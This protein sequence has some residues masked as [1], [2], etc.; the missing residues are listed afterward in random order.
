MNKKDKKLLTLLDI[1]P[2][3]LEDE[4]TTTTVNRGLKYF[5]DG[6]VKDITGLSPPTEQDE[7]LSIEGVVAGRDARLYKTIVN[8]ELDIFGV[9]I[10]SRCSCPVEHNCKHGIALLFAFLNASSQQQNTSSAANDNDLTKSDIEVEQ[11]LQAIEQIEEEQESNINIAPPSPE[12][13][14]F[15]L[16]YILED[17]QP[18]YIGENNEGL[19][20]RYVKARA[21]KKGGYGQIYNINYYDIHEAYY[22]PNCFYNALDETIVT[23]LNALPSTGYGIEERFFLSSQIGEISLENMLKTGRCFW[24]T[25]RSAPLHLGEVRPVTLSWEDK[26]EV[27]APTI[28]IDPPVD[29]LF[30]LERFYYLDTQQ[31]KIGRAEHE[32]L[33]KNKIIFFKA[34]PTIPKNNAEAMSKKILNALPSVDFPLP[35]ELDIQQIEITDIRPNFHLKLHAVQRPQNPLTPNVSAGTMHIASLSFQYGEVNYKPK[36]QSDLDKAV[37]VFLEDGNRYTL[38]RALA[39]EQGAIHTLEAIGFTPLTKPFDISDMALLGDE[40]VAQ[41]I[42]KW[43]IFQTEKIPELRAAGWR[44]DIDDSFELEL[45]II[46]DWFADLDESEAGDWFEMNLGFELNGVRVNLL[47]L[48]VQLLADNPDKDSLHQSLRDKTHQIFQLPSG[49]WIKIPTQR[50]LQIL[51]TIIELYDTD[52]LTTD[53][54]LNIDKYAGLHFNELLNDPSLRWKGADELKKLNKKLRNFEGIESVDLPKGLSAELRN[55]QK[56]GL[57]WLQ[58]L[59][60][61]QFHGI[62]ADDMGLGKTVQTLANLLLEK[63]NGR[64]DLPSVVIAP[65]S[66]MSN[67]KN[68]AKKFTPDLSVLILQGPNRKDHFDKIKEYDLILTTYPLM[69]RDKELY[70]DNE[71][72]YL[73]LDEAQAIKNVKAKTTQIIYKI[74]ARHRL[75]VTGTPMENHLGEIWSM[76]HFLMPGYLGTHERFNRLFRNPIEKNA[77]ETRGQVLRQRIEPFLLRRSKEV[78][79]TELPEK[80]EMIRMVT[81]SGKQRDLYETVR[82]AMDKKVRDEI[83][84]KGLARS[85]IMILDALLKLRQVCCDPKLVKLEKARKV[86]ESA[87]L[88]LLMTMVPEM[89]EEGRKILIFSQ[90]TAML[91]IIEAKLKKAKIKYTKLTGQTRKRAEAIDAFQEGDA[92]VFLISLKA[93]GVGLNLTAADTVIHY[94]PWWNPAAEKQATDRAYR[95]GQDKPVFVYK[96]LTEGTVEEKILL[97][98]EKKQALA[99]ALYAKKDNT[100]TSFDQ[101]DL[102]DLLKPLE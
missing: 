72:H 38:H 62:L 76:Y 5:N 36:T 102:M 65:T 74:K 84:K 61:Y 70:Q 89:L 19:A 11:W 81:L 6:H 20:V 56:E 39:D 42:E 59:R 78:V 73:I 24:Q 101:N 15:H 67:W 1:N 96:L 94:D 44:I 49:Q 88:E 27:Y 71:F 85:H 82:L 87:K 58:F 75:C 16:I 13:E 52:A 92:K 18:R 60:N 4:F 35:V 64:A 40:S 54:T 25:Q 31:H 45:E 2:K 34:A 98:Q 47:P 26:G 37:A 7:V 100:Q 79:A 68:E 8:I 21:L 55:Y 99:D 97:M 86:K 91:G 80:T 57:N 46:D 77:D 12:V 10:D 29:N 23:A 43:D 3:Y 14:N 48:L 50:V 28:N 63:E 32:S 93:G 41:S 33:D 53:G 9:D 90:F 69:V 95:I 30:P 22:S 17:Y 51:D 83:A 66:L